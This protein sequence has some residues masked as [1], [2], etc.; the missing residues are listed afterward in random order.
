V[1]ADPREPAEETRDDEEDQ[2]GLP[3]VD[4][5]LSFVRVTTLKATGRVSVLP[6]G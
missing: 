4:A 2:G 6:K 3:D 1:L 5:A